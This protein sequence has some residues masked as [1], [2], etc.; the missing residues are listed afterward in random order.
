MPLAQ[1][2]T[3]VGKSGQDAR[4]D[5]SGLQKVNGVYTDGTYQYD[6]R[7][8]DLSG[9]KAENISGLRG[10]DEN[11]VDGQVSYAG[12]GGGGGGSAY[13]QYAAQAQQAYDT[14]MAQIRAERQS[15]RSD[16]GLNTDGTQLDGM[17]FLGKF[18]QMN[19]N[20]ASVLDL[21]RDSLVGRGLGGVGLSNRLALAPKYDLDVG[22][23]DLGNSYQSL[24]QQLAGRENDANAQLQQALLMAMM[25]GGYGGYDGGGGDGEE[26]AGPFLNPAGLDDFGQALP[27]NRLP[28]VR[29]QVNPKPAARKPTAIKPLSK[30]PGA[31]NRAGFR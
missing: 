19:R 7:G 2:L 8:L 21:S 30:G 20:S 18:Q 13:G 6:D 27:A 4:Y 16:Y 5:I 31:L 28:G 9:R 15:S 22:Y 25:M 23:K 26:A 29:Y 24:M 14:T 17:N 11:F 1:Q 10:A 12:G 3:N